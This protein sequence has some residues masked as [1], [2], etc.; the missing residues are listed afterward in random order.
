MFDLG[1]TGTRKGM[2]ES[3][4]NEVRD[5]F[6]LM[7]RLW[8]TRGAATLHHGD[9][10]GSDAQAHAI[11]VS[12]GWRICIHPPTDEKYRAFCDSE[13]TVIQKPFV[14]LKRNRDI[15]SHSVVV[16]AAPATGKSAGTKYTIS[17]AYSMRKPVYRVMPTGDMERV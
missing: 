9:C 4:E 3:Q 13:L 17:H 5:F 7:D 11:A 8:G 14:Y 15:V 10:V 6:A 1:F 16:V 12:L 2:T